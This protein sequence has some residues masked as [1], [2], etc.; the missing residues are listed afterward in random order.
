MLNAADFGINKFIYTLRVGVR[1]VGNQQQIWIGVFN[2]TD[3]IQ[4]QSRDWQFFISST[5]TTQ[6]NFLINFLHKFWR[7]DFCKQHWHARGPVYCSL[8][9]YLKPSSNYCVTSW[10]GYCDNIFSNVSHLMG[11]WPRSH[12]SLRAKFLWGQTRAE[13]LPLHLRQVC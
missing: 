11:K 3:R 8:N 1:Q 12:M 13:W 2:Q 9:P 5:D 6:L 10:K 4:S 7:I